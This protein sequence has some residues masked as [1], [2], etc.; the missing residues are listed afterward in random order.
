MVF[1]YRIFTGKRFHGQTKLLN[2]L[3]RKIHLFALLE[4]TSIWDLWLML[5]TTF[6]VN[7]FRSPPRTAKSK[8][9]SLKF[10]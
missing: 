6:R 4:P 8:P 9:L 2:K 7:V 1:N 5:G 10:S 3:T